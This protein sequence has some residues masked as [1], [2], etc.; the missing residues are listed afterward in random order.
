VVLALLVRTRKASTGRPAP[1]F[2]TT[3]M[4]ARNVLLTKPK[5]TGN[6]F[7]R[8]GVEC[9]FNPEVVHSF[10]ESNETTLELV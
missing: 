8:I 7:K 6:S 2:F 3:G 5:G 1:A 10:K 9:V 4:K